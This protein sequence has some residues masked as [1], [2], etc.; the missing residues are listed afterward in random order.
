MKTI[1]T[2]TYVILTIACF[3]VFGKNS[4]LSDAEKQAIQILREE[5]KLA[6]DVYSFLYEK[7]ELP[8]FQNISNSETR[9]FE[10]IG[11]LIET[12]ELKD[13]ANLF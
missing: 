9:H 4:D 13:P 7:W 2:F 6:H 1:F 12:F 5:E 3:S 8:I 11:Y 10:A